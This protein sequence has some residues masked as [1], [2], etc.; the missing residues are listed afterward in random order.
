MDHFSGDH[1]PNQASDSV[2]SGPSVQIK[3]KWVDHDSARVNK[4][5]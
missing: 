1:Y 4:L 5:N 2:H 3:G